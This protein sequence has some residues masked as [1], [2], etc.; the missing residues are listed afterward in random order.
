[1][2]GWRELTGYVVKA[3]EQLSKEE[4]N[5]CTIYVERDYGNAG[6]INF[7]GKEYNLPDAVTFL[8]SYVIWAPE[9][10]PVGPFIYV[11]SEIGDI[12]KL[13]NNVTKIGSVSN[14][15]SRENGLLVFL[16]TDPAANVPE[17]YRQK[18]VN[19]KKRYSR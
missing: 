4:Q 16:C 15:Y 14:S 12:K 18:A 7:Y 11:N 2:T 1:M 9:N 10:I 6:A 5:R 19:E 17:V 13:F 3:Y 8:E